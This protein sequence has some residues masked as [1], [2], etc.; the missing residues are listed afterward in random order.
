MKRLKAWLGFVYDV[1]RIIFLRE[2][3]D[4][5]NPPQDEPTN[6]EKNI[7]PVVKISPTASSMIAPATSPPKREEP[8]P[9]EGSIEARRSSLESR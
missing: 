3:D 7:A 2:W 4:E 6:D 5:P 8:T 1:G 9:L